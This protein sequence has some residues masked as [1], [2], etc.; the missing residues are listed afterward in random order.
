LKVDI[1]KN[2]EIISDYY[3]YSVINIKVL[4]IINSKFENESEII[5]LNV[6]LLKNL[7]NFIIISFLKI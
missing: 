3:I 6:K 7:F 4:K 1:D 5:G 2:Q